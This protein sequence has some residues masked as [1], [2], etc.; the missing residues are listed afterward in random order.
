MKGSIA[1]LLVVVVAGLLLWWLGGFVASHADENQNFLAL[2]GAAKAVRAGEPIYPVEAPAP[3]KSRSA[4][5]LEST[6]AKLSAEAELEST[7]AA[8]A[9]ESAR[10]AI[11]TAEAPVTEAAPATTAVGTAKPAARTRVIK[12]KTKEAEARP[13]FRYPPYVA[14]LFI[15]LTFIETP[16]TA[17]LVW[18]WVNVVFLFLTMGMSTF[19][20]TGSY[21]P[22]RRWMFVV[23]LFAVAPF[24][25]FFLPTQTLTL[26]AVLLVAAS[27]ALFKSEV[28][29]VAGFAAAMA[30]FSPFGVAMGVYYILKRAWAALLGYFAGVLVLLAVLPIV[31]LGAQDA[32]EAMEGYRTQTLAPM[33]SRIGDTEAIMASEN[34][35]VWAMLAR[36][37]NEIEW[38]GGRAAQYGEEYNVSV[39]PKLTANWSMAVFLGVGAILIIGSLFGVT[40]K[41]RDRRGPI[42]GLEGALVVLATLLLTPFSY[43][44]EMVAMV[45]PV[46]AVV[47]VIMST[48]LRRFVHHVNY[49]GLVLATAFFYLTLDP[50]FR[51]GGSAFAG[52]FILWVAV[53]AGIAH[54]RPQIVHG[55]ARASF[56]TSTRELDKPIDLAKRPARKE[57]PKVTKS[58]LPLPDFAQEEANK[59]DAPTGM[60]KVFMYFK[61]KETPPVELE[62]GP[63]PGAEEHE[64]PKD[65]NKRKKS[66]G[67]DRKIPLE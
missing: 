41:L 19:A 21:S 51:I 52:T 11:A 48:D 49:V 54:F 13:E 66:G 42:V 23:S 37:S 5:L 53:L 36:R 15:P 14:M 20:L 22:G 28:D 43:I 27:L 58:I 31:I 34:Q 60:A 10:S 56:P 1:L 7:A 12:P 57:E 61:G 38:V 4:K 64:I 9:D 35:S 2:Y 59:P 3:L 45:L 17:A 67:D 46:L 24:V 62:G 33:W 6:E 40:R 30:I 65:R 55:R 44:W 39:S 8:A 29:A 63:E 18:Y 50:L 25:Y 47:H 26:V 32:W 16:K